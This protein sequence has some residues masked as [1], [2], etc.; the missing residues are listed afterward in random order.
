MVMSKKEREFFDS[1]DSFKNYS[2]IDEYKA[3]IRRWLTLSSWHYSEEKA[4]ELMEMAERAVWIEQ[5]FQNKEPA[6][7]I[8]ADVGYCCG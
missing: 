8:A 7:A 4:N 6:S 5:A 3:D 2:N 1:C